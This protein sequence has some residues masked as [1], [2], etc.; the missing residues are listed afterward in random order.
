M[1]ENKTVNEQELDNV[2]GGRANSGYA[3]H[4]VERG[5]TLYKLAK[6]YLTTIEEILYLNPIIT[7][8]NFIRV[9]WELTIPDN[10]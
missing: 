4:R 2:T 1:D 8:R 6:H 10:R 5:D 3:I 9:G 7:D